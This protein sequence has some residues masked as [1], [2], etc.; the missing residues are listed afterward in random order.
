MTDNVNHPPHYKFSNGA[1]SID[2]TENLTSNGGQAVA[3]LVRSTRID[4]NNK[5][6]THEGLVEDLRKAEFYVKREI[7]RI[8]GDYAPE[9]VLLSF[10]PTV[11][12]EEPVVVEE[13][14]RVW[15]SVFDIPHGTTVTQKGSSD[16]LFITPT[17]GGW[18]LGPGEVPSRSRVGWILATKD[19]RN[20]PFTEVLGE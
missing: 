6:G 10:D 18:F 19:D 14:P 5:A 20:G 16:R 12:P 11:A 17:G 4:G 13:E 1:E 7:A 2:I 8:A 9:R 3:Y 15:K